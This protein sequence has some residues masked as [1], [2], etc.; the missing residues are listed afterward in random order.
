MRASLDECSRRILAGLW[1]LVALIAILRPVGG[2]AQ[3]VVE[4]RLPDAV[5]RALGS[6]EG[7]RRT[8]VREELLAANP[9]ARTVSV[10][11]DLDRFSV[12][13][14]LPDG[15][16]VQVAG[17]RV[18]AYRMV[19]G[20][21]PE[22]T[23]LVAPPEGYEVR[24]AVQEPGGW[25]LTLVPAAREPGAPPPAGPGEAPQRPAL[26]EALRERSGATLRLLASHRYRRPS[27]GGLN[28][29]NALL[30]LS[31]QTSEGEVR[32]DLTFDWSR[33]SLLAK[34]RLRWT[35]DHW[36][37]GPGSGD[38]ETDTELELLEG[39]AQLRLAD[40]LFLAFGRENLQWGPGQLLNPS[41]PFLEDNGRDN[42]IREV[43]G[44]DF[45]R[46]VWLP[47]F[48]WT[49]SWISNVGAGEN[50]VPSGP[51][52]PSHALKVEYVGY[53]VNGG[54]LVHDGPRRKATLRG[55][56]QWTV[57]DA[58]LLYAEASV[59]KGTTA[60]Y[61]AGASLAPTR[62]DDSDLLPFTLLGGAY[63]LEIGPTVSA[64]Y[65]YNGEGYDPGE[66]WG[67]F[68]LVRGAGQAAQ[69]GL[70][71]PDPDDF[72]T[73]LRLLR[74]HYLFLQYLQTEIADRFSV[75]LRWTQNLE[76][77]SGLATGFGEWNL[78]DRWRLFGFGG[79]GSGGNRDEFGSVVRYLGLLGVEY[80]AF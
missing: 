20:V 66:A 14:K 55:Y 70:L 34:P 5:L 21:A 30:D 56:G 12:A 67:F 45:F 72:T 35:R 6:P 16:S 50:E 23:R 24:P 42:P 29:D 32:L 68:D 78:S 27:L 74:R 47:N 17:S 22:A 36:Q 77:G 3:E 26:L 13:W 39:V 76:D 79:W 58:L 49:V 48:N 62:K 15:R 40:S 63:T 37:D 60:R 80:S 75:I 1:V 28:P 19:L 51:W 52:H 57:N 10:R 53:E 71:S 38:S 33:L 59:S 8:G 18:D 44:M 41:N 31:R 69:A 11:G 4:V 54:L 61:P 64:E 73:G 25:V 2:R 65:V 43:P 9:W 7:W 46:A